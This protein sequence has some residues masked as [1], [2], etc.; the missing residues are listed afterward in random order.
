[1]KFAALAAFAASL[2][3]VSASPTPIEARSSVQGFDISSYQKTVNFKAAYTDGAR[4]V[5]I[6]VRSNNFGLSSYFAQ[7][8]S[9]QATEGHTYLDPTFLL[10]L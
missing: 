10:P 5:Y 7:L 1:M 3:L 4:F 9:T 2:G 8:T 6:K